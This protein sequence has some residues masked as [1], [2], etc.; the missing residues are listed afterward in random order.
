MESACFFCT[1]AEALI[2]ALALCIVF[3]PYVL[4]N[5][6]FKMVKRLPV[7]IGGENKPL[8]R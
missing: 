3:D 2:V 4:Q 1:V 8:P 5:C 6:F 7:K